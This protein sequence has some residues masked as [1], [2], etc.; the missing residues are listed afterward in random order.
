MKKTLLLL[1][2]LSPALL[3]AQL[4]YHILHESVLATNVAEAK[5]MEKKLMLVVLL[6]NDAFA[7]NQAISESLKSDILESKDFKAFAKERGIMVVTL[8]R[9]YTAKELYFARRD[10][11]DSNKGKFNVVCYG[12]GNRFKKVGTCVVN[13]NNE[14]LAQVLVHTKDLTPKDYIDKYTELLEQE[15]DELPTPVTPDNFDPHAP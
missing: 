10:K 11:R 1:I 15:W 12:S 6:N 4:P 5:K 14:I 8:K 13:L 2:A 7:N 3:G 9:K